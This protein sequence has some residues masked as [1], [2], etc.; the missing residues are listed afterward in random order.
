MAID[1]LILIGRNKWSC[2]LIN[3]EISRM[4][5]VTA[6]QQSTSTLSNREAE[7]KIASINHNG[8]QLQL[9]T[10][11]QASTPSLLYKNQQ[12]SETAT[13]DLVSKLILKT[14]F[15]TLQYQD[16]DKSKL[17]SLVNNIW[18]KAHSNYTKQTHIRF[19]HLQ[20]LEKAAR[21]SDILVLMDNEKQKIAG[22]IQ[23]HYNYDGNQA[24]FGLLCIDE[25]YRGKKLAD[26]LI[27]RVEADAL[28]KGCTKMYILVVKCAER[29][30][31]YYNK[32]GYEP[33]GKEISRDP[34]WLKQVK[35]ECKDSVAFVEM[36]KDL[37]QSI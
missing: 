34:E 23:R 31:S 32:K 33:T 20:E 35:D 37:R 6:I 17:F 4:L 3:L 21:S 30:I 27:E 10:P 28:Q 9:L 14:G 13:S 8:R 2:F 12:A 26:K 5:P 15:S 19:Q 7:Q 36:R 16:V 29:L 18:A 22:C 24:Y 1:F 25:E 11:E